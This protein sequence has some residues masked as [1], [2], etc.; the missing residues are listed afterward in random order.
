MTSVGLV[1]DSTADLPQAVLDKHGVTMVPLIVNWDG[2]T[3]RDKLD[4]TT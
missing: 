2:K 4:L 3:Y 1:T